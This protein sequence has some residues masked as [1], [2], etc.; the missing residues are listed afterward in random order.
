MLS[1]NSMVHVHLP[2]TARWQNE[3]DHPLL[4][5][6]GRKQALQRVRSYHSNDH[7]DRRWQW[8]CRAVAKLDWSY[9]YWTGY[10]NTWDQP[11]V[12]ECPHNRVLTGVNSYH[13][14]KHE[15]RRWR[16]RCCE[17]PRHFKENCD[18]TGYINN[19]DTNIDFNLIG[20]QRVFVGAFS[21]HHN[22]HE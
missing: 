15:D 9:C 14:N 20:T 6:C 2:R 13:H 12:F 1:H 21:Y 16:F 19:W 11:F 22:T 5:S 3:M 8:D 7:E 10:Q 18:W 4:V 17:A